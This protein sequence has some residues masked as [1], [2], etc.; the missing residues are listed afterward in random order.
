MIQVNHNHHLN[1]FNLWLILCTQCTPAFLLYT[2]QN[3]SIYTL[4]LVKLALPVI[5][6]ILCMSVPILETFSYMWSKYWIQ[7]IL[8]RTRNGIVLWESL[9]KW[10]HSYTKSLNALYTSW[11]TLYSPSHSLF[12]CVYLFS[13]PASGTFSC[14]CCFCIDLRLWLWIV[15][16]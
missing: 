11:N 1:N 15:I 12:N 5:Y 4:Y 13:F 6:R 10:V 2:I 8:T 3:S 9:L 7:S 14:H 16:W